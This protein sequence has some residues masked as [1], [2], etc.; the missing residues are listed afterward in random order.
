MKLRGGCVC[1]SIEFEVIFIPEMVFN[2]HC[3]RCQ[4]S[5]GAAFAIQAFAIRNSLKFI[6]GRDNLKEYKSKGSIRTFCGNC[7]L[8]LMNYATNNEDYLSI[9]LSC[10]DT[11]HN[12]AP[13]A[14]VCV[15]SKVDWCELSNKIPQF[16][17][18]A[19]NVTE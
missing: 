7:G 19:A 12:L 9:A 3:T 5:H 11:P 2:C 6:R 1:S 13:V 10:V 16:A 14:N 18:L 15:S 8:I 17:E 4:K